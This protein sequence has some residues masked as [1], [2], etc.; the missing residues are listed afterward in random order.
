MDIFQGWE[1]TPN[2]K[3]IAGTQALGSIQEA[4]KEQP[5]GTCRVWSCLELLPA[6]NKKGNLFNF[7]PPEKLKMRNKG[8]FLA[9]FEALEKPH[10]KCAKDNRKDLGKV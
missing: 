2:I 3:S 1:N 4:S 6:V 9:L 10:T 8:L 7:F 5:E